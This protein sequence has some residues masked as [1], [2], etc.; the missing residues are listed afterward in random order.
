MYKYLSSENGYHKIED[1]ETGI[2][3][4]L[5]DEEL[6]D[7]L[8]LVCQIEGLLIDSR[9]NIIDEFGRTVVKRKDHLNNAKTAKKDEFY[10]RY[11]DIDKELSQYHVDVFRE[12]VIY[13]P[14]DVAVSGAKVPVS[15]FVKWFVDNANRLQF[16]MLVCSCLAS[17]ASTS[18]EGVA[19][20]KNLYVLRRVGDHYEEYLDHCDD[21]ADYESGDYRSPFCESLFS[22]CDIVV[23]NPPYSQFRQFMKSIDKYSKDFILIANKNVLAF[24]D[25]FSISGLVV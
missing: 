14:C 3:E 7:A 2:A 6:R 15:N 11:V 16:K 21:C 17:C 13:L 23:T 24:K 10:T 22:E 4:L 1:S 5:N 18:H 20:A 12:K 8:S 19:E 25:M 9:H